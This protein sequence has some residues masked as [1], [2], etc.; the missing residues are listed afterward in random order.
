MALAQRSR[1]EISPTGAALGAVI[2]GVDL[3]RPLDPDTFKDIHDAWMQHLVLIFPD[4]PLSDA[5]HVAFGRNFGEQEIFHQNL[6]K[7]QR[8]PEIF[9]VANTDED[10]NLLP[11]SNE[12]VHQLSSAQMWHTDSSYRPNPSKGSI[13]RGLEVVREGGETLFANMY[14]V[15]DALPADLRARVEGRKARHNFE[16]LRVLRDLPPVSDAERAA[17]PPVWQP[18]VRRHPVTGRRSLYISVIYNDE[19]EG[20]SPDEGKAFV[21]Q[22][23]AF[24]GQPRF[25]YRHKW[26]P[27]DVVMWDNRCTIH[28]VTPYDPT[29]RRVLHRTT[30]VGD[31]P[32]IAA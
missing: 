11:P 31:G 26:R 13:L 3:R 12:A 20:M 14:A 19:V 29:Q 27:N 2:R 32:V 23:A 21:E 9:R 16:Y 18:M 30:I 17:M 10:G 15:L 25:V 7:S 1:I 6:I 5:E 4:Q 28:Q 24:A 8:Q 22:L